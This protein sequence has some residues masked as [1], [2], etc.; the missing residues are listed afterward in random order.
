MRRFFKIFLLLTVANVAVQT[1]RAQDDTSDDLQRLADLYSVGKY[2]QVLQQSLHL[3]DS[4]HLSKDENL[5][6]LKYTVAAYKEFGYRREADSVARL[7]FQKAPLYKE[8]KSD[9]EP[10]REV[11]SNYYTMPKYSV[12][13]A[14]GMH[15]VS[16]VL[17]TVRPIIDAAA[18]KPEYDVKGN[19]LQIGFA[20]RVLR[21]L[22]VSVAPTFAKYEMKRTMRRSDLVTF[23]YNE[24]CKTFALPL[25]VE[26]GLYVFGEK[27]VPSVYGGAQFKYILGTKSNAYTDAIGTYTEVPDKHDDTQY[28]NRTNYSVL[29]GAR[30]NYNQKRITFFLDFGVSYDLKPYND[31][32]KKFDDIALMYQDL[33]IRDVFQLLEYT[34]KVGIKVNL[35]YKTIAK[36]HYG[37]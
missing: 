24:S 11:L 17:N 15:F 18:V 28:K 32:D 25:M 27:L 1:A 29:G 9:P 19:S 12:W 13:M 36:H 35:Q 16:P 30:L 3:G 26:A 2:D 10:F 7:F 20:Y 33:Y 37:Y 34:A 4:H 31:P 6:R 5:T 8:Q 21:L 14:G 23:R 22:S